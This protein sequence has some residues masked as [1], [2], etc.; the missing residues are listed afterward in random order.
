[1]VAREAGSIVLVGSRVVER[2]WAGK[3]ASA[4]TVAKS[5]VVALAQVTAAE[6]LSNGV[7]INAV[8]PS[9]IDTPSNRA[10]SGGKAPSGSIS[11][12]SLSNVIGFLLSEAARDV[13]GAVLPVYGLAG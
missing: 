12:E 1:M 6:V 2:P 7:R 9:A 13:S 5:A 11:T 4:Y 8:L 10:F 3:G